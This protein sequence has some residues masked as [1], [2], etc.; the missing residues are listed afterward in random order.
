[1]SQEKRI[2]K[3]A[4]NYDFI[5]ELIW[6]QDLRFAINCNDVFMWGC[7]DAEEITTREDVDL[8]QQAC[9]DSNDFGP[10]LY[11]ARKQGMRPQGAYY[12]YIDKNDW[13]LFNACGPEREI[14]FGN[15]KKQG[16]K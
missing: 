7:A 2:L 1:M 8:L 15:P 14:C 6:D 4:Q 12:R 13:E 10:L 3:L 11:C 16:E 9:R 5:D